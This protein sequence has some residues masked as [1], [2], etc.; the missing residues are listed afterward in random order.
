ME[1]CLPYLCT[2]ML[3]IPFYLINLSDLSMKLIYL[4]I[5]L[6]VL[7]IDL[8]AIASAIAHAN[9]MDHVPSHSPGLSAYTEAS[10]KTED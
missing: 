7:S 4:S 9:A 5:S 3:C 10:P 6:F 8:I 1:V 2:Y